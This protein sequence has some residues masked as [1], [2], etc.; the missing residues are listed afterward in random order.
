MNQKQALILTIALGV[1][2]GL[3]NLLP[4]WFLDSSEFLFGQLFVLFVLLLC[5]WRYAVIA[6]AVGA[7]FLFYRWGHCWPS[8]VF[9]L[10]VL[11]LQFVCARFGKPFFVRGL[12][13]WFLFG[14]PIL[15]IF[16][17]FTLELPL[18]VIF[19]ALAKYLI[20]AGIC[21]AVVDLLSF[22]FTRS[23][24]Q[25]MPLNQILNSTVNLVIVLVVLTTTIVLTN[26]YYQRIEKEI[27]TQ[28][29]AASQSITAQIDDYLDA[30]RR[31]MVISASD[32]ALGIDKAYVIE[33]LL[34]TYSNF[35]TAIV[36]DAEANVTHFYPRH[37][38]DM[39]QGVKANVSDRDYFT[40]AIDN[41]SGYVSG[42]FQGRG[43]DEA[44][45]VA[46]SAPIYKEGVFNGIVEGSLI[47]GSFERFIPKILAQDANLVVIDKNKRVVFSSLMTEFKTLDMP[48]GDVLSALFDTQAAVYS[49]STG[50]LLFKQAAVSTQYEWSVI[51][52]LD[53]KYLNFVAAEAWLY[54]AGLALVIILFSSVFVRQ[55]TRLLVR[56]IVTLSRDIRA[57][58]PSALI[59]NSA[60]SDSSF[61]EIVEL[62]QQFN[63]L[64]F[65]LTLSFTKQNQARI[66]NERL[67]SKLTDFNR[68]LEQQVTEK[69]VELTK[70]LEDANAASK[71]KSRF[72]A[73]M[74]H[75]IRTPL[76]GIIG[77]ADNLLREES[78][79][80]D[81]REQLTIIAQSA[82][83]LML[84][85]NDILDYSKI[86]AGALKI[87][88][89]AID[90]HKM[91]DSLVG[92]FKLANVKLGVAFRYEKDPRLPRYLL[93]D[94]L[95]VTQIINNL[96]NNA[97]KFTHQGHIIL[98]VEYR[99]SRLNL[100]ISDSGIGISQAQQEVLFQEFT[101]ADLSTTRK[102]GGTGLGLA[103][104]KKLI[105]AMDGEITLRS[106][107]GVGSEFVVNIPA[108]TG[109]KVE[110]EQQSV[111]VP[112]LNGVSILL[113]EDNMINQVVVGKLL[114]KT[115]CKLDKV[116]DGI[117]ALSA[118]K[119]KSY[120]LVLM[121]CQM[122]N[123]DGFSCTKAIRNEPEVF[124]EPYI[125]AITANAY[126]EDKH[127]CLQ[128][129]MDDFLSKPIDVNELYQKLAQ[130]QQTE[131]KV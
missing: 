111:E 93:L 112:R 115:Q 74:S 51:T 31:A 86:E 91:L 34:N 120:T 10:E 102:F 16:G 55:L 53:R 116:N 118:I 94:E 84:I 63:Q 62:Q 47:F 124:G 105:E 50:Q 123:M 65:K 119:A 68:E 98:A 71:S 26:N 110:V 57:Y 106:E 117:E 73:N 21:L 83:N 78:L 6:V 113:V 20:N 3:A 101:Q 103:I 4:I 18:L 33:R 43:F 61:L 122:P 5:G 72:L 39:M 95:R 14:L 37:F 35:R 41:P 15:F 25:G 81:T 88:R 87:E 22:F 99:Q 75:E 13:F 121:D 46:I 67:N 28:L 19:T 107:L 60:T 69:T 85:L 42:I 8:L 80:V 40:Y 44:P 127:K 131:M 90:V 32:V 100:S 36:T 79:T 125:I 38:A 23:K 64:A 56:P 9:L 48:S 45:I 97:G 27:N 96:L 52:L 82:K 49:G 11:W 128:A 70:A 24:W 89:R 108:E 77:M 17:Y 130:W 129:G 92:V 1:L 59:E 54:A 114:E 29:E 12:A 58:E 2:G 7:S 76:N 66:E 30:Y 109:E 126:E 104:T